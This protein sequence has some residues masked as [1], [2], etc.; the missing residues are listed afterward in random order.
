M[1][2]I[3]QVSTVFCLMLTVTVIVAAAPPNGTLDRTEMINGHEVQ[4]TV[5]KDGQITAWVTNQA[6]QTH[7]HAVPLYGFWG[8]VTNRGAAADANVAVNTVWSGGVRTTQ[9]VH[10]CTEC[11][12][13]A[14]SCNIESGYTLMASL[15]TTGGHA[16]VTHHSY[17][18]DD[19]HIRH[20]FDMNVLMFYKK[21]C[22]I[23]HDDS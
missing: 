19:D 16:P 11:G 3:A 15:N 14:K 10:T 4:Y 23:H 6:G 20:D 18:C 21:I 7:Q 17:R 22:D 9:D 5:E 12:F 2:K 1:N 13:W 8:Y